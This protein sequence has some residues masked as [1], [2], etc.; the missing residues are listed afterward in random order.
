MIRIY[1]ESEDTYRQLVTSN[2]DTTPYA[3]EYSFVKRDGTS[4]I[5]WTAGTWDGTSDHTDLFVWQRWSLTPKIGPDGGGDIA[6][7]VG[8]W[9]VYARINERLF[10]VD[11]IE[12]VAAGT[13]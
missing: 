9:D 1:V 2:F 12:V 7:S 8:D 6:L 10:H 13:P 11:L 3:I 5:A 4:A